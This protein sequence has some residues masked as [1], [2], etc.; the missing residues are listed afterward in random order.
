MQKLSDDLVARLISTRNATTGLTNKRQLLFA[1][2]DQMIHSTPKSNSA[3][4]LGQ[5]Q[6]E[7]MLIDMTP[8]TNF[9]ASFGHLAGGYDA[10]YYGYLWSEVFSMDMFISRFK[11]D[12]LRNQKTGVAYREMILARGGSVDASDM[13]Q[14]FLGR[15]PND[16][17]FLLSKGLN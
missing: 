9:A 14:D 8:G 5:L 7:I 4:L 1:T 16:N 11:K 3:E 15:A 12:G 10:Q 13:L 2:F 17:A 6:S